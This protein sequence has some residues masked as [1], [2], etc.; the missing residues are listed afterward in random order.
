VIQPPGFAFFS[1]IRPPPKNQTDFEVNECNQDFAPVTSRTT[2]LPVMPSRQWRLL[3]FVSSFLCVA[4]P[5]SAIVVEGRVYH[6]KQVQCIHG[7][8]W[9]SEGNLGAYSRARLYKE[10]VFT[11][12]VQSA[13]EISFTDKRLQII[14]DE[15]LFGDVAREIIATVNQACLPENLPEIKAGDKWLFFLRT[16][17]YLHPDA[18]PPYITTDGLMV[19]FDSPA[20]PVS[21]AEYDICN[22]RL[23]SDLAE[24]C[25][26][27][28][29]APPRE[30]PDF[31]C[32]LKHFP[33]TNPFPQP[34]PLQELGNSALQRDG[35]NLKRIAA[36]PE[37]RAPDPNALNASGLILQ[38]RRW[39]T[40]CSPE[41]D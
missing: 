16:K 14:P 2:I 17:Q 7:G 31:S 38:P 24:S 37:F 10:Q 8:A 13:I 5:L 32:G 3:V 26:A 1:T 34:V 39:L 19:D 40:S 20:K 4:P 35:I 21:L 28:M 36:P 6:G 22:L 11:G 18:N 23:H 15:I 25:I 33:S 41:E 9:I 12:T 29:P 27:L 30:E